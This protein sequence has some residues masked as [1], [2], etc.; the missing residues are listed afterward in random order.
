MDSTDDSQLY[1]SLLKLTLATVTTTIGTTT[2]A[3]DTANEME[4]RNALARSLEQRA[5]DESESLEPISLASPVPSNNWKNFTAIKYWIHIDSTTSEEE[6]D[7]WSTK[8]PA[9]WATLASSDVEASFYSGLILGNLFRHVRTTSRYRAPKRPVTDVLSLEPIS[10]WWALLR[11][12]LTPSEAPLS[13]ATNFSNPLELLTSSAVARS[14]P[15]LAVFSWVCW[16]FQNYYKR[17]LLPKEVLE[18]LSI[19]LELKNLQKTRETVHNGIPA[20]ITMMDI[21]RQQYR[22]YA[23][24]PKDQKELSPAPPLRDSLRL[25]DTLLAILE[26][27]NVS[28]HTLPPLDRC[29]IVS[30]TLR[31]LAPLSAVLADH[32]PLEKRQRCYN[33]SK[34]LL[35]EHVEN[36]PASAHHHARLSSTVPYE[37]SISSLQSQPPVGAISDTEDMAVRLCGIALGTIASLGKTHDDADWFRFRCEEA[38]KEDGITS[39]LLRCLAPRY[40]RYH[41]LF[42]VKAAVE[43]SCI[44]VA[45]MSGNRDD[46]VRQKA[47]HHFFQ[48]GITACLR[49]HLL[50]CT[51]FPNWLEKAQ[52]DFI[53]AH[54]AD[55]LHLDLKYEQS[56]LAKSWFSNL[57]PSLTQESLEAKMKEIWPLEVCNHISRALDLMLPL[58]LYLGN[59]IHQSWLFSFLSAAMPSK[60]SRQPSI[61]HPRTLHFKIPAN[62]PLHWETAWWCLGVVGVDP[63]RTR[64]VIRLFKRIYTGAHAISKNLI[65]F[66]Y[67]YMMQFSIHQA[68]R[69]Q[70]EAFSGVPCLLT[71]TFS[72]EHLGYYAALGDHLGT[73]SLWKSIAFLKLG[74]FGVYT[75]AELERC[76]ILSSSFLTNLIENQRQVLHYCT[77]P[78]LFVQYFL[79]VSASD[80]SVDQLDQLLGLSPPVLSDLST[81]SE[82]NLWTPYTWMLDRITQMCDF[83][84]PAMFEALKETNK[85]PNAAVTLANVKFLK[86]PTCYTYSDNGSN[87]TARDVESW[88]GSCAADHSLWYHGTSRISAANILANGVQPQR[89]KSHDF[90][91]EPVFY[92]SNDIEVA[93]QFAMFKYGSGAAVVVFH[94]PS[95]LAQAS[96]SYLEKKKDV[97]P[98]PPFNQEEMEKEQ[99]EDEED[100]EDEVDD[101]DV[102]LRPCIFWDLG[103]DP[104][105]S[106]Q[107]L[108]YLSHNPTCKR[109]N[110]LNWLSKRSKYMKDKKKALR[111]AKDLVLRADSSD[112]V[113][114]RMMDGPTAIP[115]QN[116]EIQLATFQ[117]VSYYCTLAIKGVILF[118]VPPKPT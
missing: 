94:L 54:L 117:S 62:L 104:L 101:F 14:L 106:W 31:S 68:K 37:E 112:F 56:I 98:L 34:D 45:G 49:V 32:F 48:S 80:C 77:V 88:F 73:L 23:I 87:I 63:W 9:L 90:G 50:L 93:T 116:Q 26:W 36:L 72:Q 89:P 115:K 10:T 25:A 15:H 43:A 74:L 79:Q 19:R 8:I 82:L 85:A 51:A 38:A 3:H 39:V 92:L 75:Q 55:C 61:P 103:A 60:I 83:D 30:A 13:N 20:M 58:P 105:D 59:S 28:T 109:L 24:H 100:E 78:Q 67:D 69:A 71:K 110:R 95:N 6:L 81:A 21:F 97:L 40:S 2:H 96:V 12:L 29:L 91:T 76:G 33:F 41:H 47:M 1:L 118:N 22:F 18:W 46:T 42:L 99:E 86:A 53:C 107:L 27:V 57:L 4:L 66:T 11:G 44:M 108:T 102:L 65:E 64:N 35:L 7:A 84:P 70:N 17:V 52:Q 111:A 113:Q 114:G 16:E 5:K